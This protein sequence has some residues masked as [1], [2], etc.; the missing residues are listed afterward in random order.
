[1]LVKQCGEQLERKQREMMEWKVRRRLPA[2]L[3]ACSLACLLRIAAS[4]TSPSPAYKTK[5]NK[6]QIRQQTTQEIQAQQ[7]KMMAQQ[8]GSGGGGGGGGAS[9]VLA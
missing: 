3:L 9:G 5:Q 4:H 6:Y 2:C 7:Q 1:M 8:T